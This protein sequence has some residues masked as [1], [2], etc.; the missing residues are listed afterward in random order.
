MGLEERPY[1]DLERVPVPDH[2]EPPY[3]RHFGMPSYEVCDCCGFEFGNDDEPGT[4]EGV[5]FATYLADWMS[6]G[7]T[8]A[9]PRCKPTGWSLEGQLAEAGI[10]Q[11]MK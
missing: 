8:W 11:P 2:V 6:R 9:N 4:A 7:A 10:R 3:S 1:Q 5:S